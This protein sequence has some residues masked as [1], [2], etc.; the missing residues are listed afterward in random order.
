MKPNIKLFTILLLLLGLIIAAGCASKGTNGAATSSNGVAVTIFKSITCGC[1]DLYASYMGK[2]GFN[3]EVK[4]TDDL[5]PIKNRYNVPS[6][7]ESCH[8]T[9]IGEYFVEGHVPVEAIEKLLA[10]KPDVAGIGMPG[11]PSGS[12]GMPGAKQGQ[13]II[14]SINKDGTI[15]EFMRI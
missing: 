4:Q 6:P 3:V 1:C 12:P 10:E 5:T 2:K 11:M 13:F 14:Y 15:N 8:T 7:M 9:V